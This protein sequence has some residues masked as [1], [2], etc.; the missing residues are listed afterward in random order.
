MKTK[1]IYLSCL[2]VFLYINLKAQNTTD[3]LTFKKPTMIID[4]QLFGSGIFMS[5]NYDTRFKPG[6][7]GLGFRGGLGFAFGGT[8]PLSINYLIGNNNK[9]S[10]LEIGAGFT[11]YVPS[12]SGWDLYSEIS[13][14]P[15]TYIMYRYQALKSPI[16]FRIGI[17]Q[18]K[19]G[20]EPADFIPY[21]PTLSLGYI[22]GRR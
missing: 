21:Y 11:C 20:N 2:F 16:T 14:V 5:V 6:N 8:I 19:I 12:N 4:G 3:T 10:F 22:L 7:K 9:R 1:S 17:S 18:I 15:N 13:F